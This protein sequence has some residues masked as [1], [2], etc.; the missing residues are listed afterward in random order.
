MAAHDHPEL[1]EK[2][3]NLDERFYEGM[4]LVDAAKGGAELPAVIQHISGIL[5]EHDARPERI[6]KWAESKLAYRIKQAERGIYILVY[7]WADPAKTEELRRDITL[8][9]DL[10][11]V[12]I[13]RAEHDQ[14][15]EPR[16]QLYS[17]EGKEVEPEPAPA[18]EEAEEAETTE[19]SS[20]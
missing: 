12:L 19:Q 17:P 2:E 3:R 10:L 6:E 5:G 15:P 14:M 18:S 20:S 7:F 11:R 1:T 13:L 9:E 4:F 8:S 16:G